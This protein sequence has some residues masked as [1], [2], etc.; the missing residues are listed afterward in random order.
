MK[1]TPKEVVK[2]IDDIDFVKLYDKGYRIIISDLDNTLAPYTMEYPS[3]DLINKIDTIKNIG[4]KI[5]LV[6]N[7]NKQ[8]LEKFTQAFNING[9]LD[10]A[11]KPRIN[12]LTK[13]LNELKI[14]I[15]EVIGLGDQLVTDILAF[16]R[17]NTYSILVKT[18]DTKTQKWY[19][20]IN[21]IREKSIIKQIKKENI[22]IGRKLEEL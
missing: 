20:K 21:R 4:F 5:Y 10:K 9:Y 2:S 15:D 11:N 3:N 1:Y 12:K 13:Y 6:S 17:L 16:N 19:T 18:I 14:N 22:E 8:R 7:N